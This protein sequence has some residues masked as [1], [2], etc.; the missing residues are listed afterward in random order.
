[1]INKYVCTKEGLVVKKHGCMNLKKSAVI[2]NKR[3]Q[4]ESTISSLNLEQ[5]FFRVFD[6]VHSISIQFAQ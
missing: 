6:K 3:G 2:V 4:T 5:V 1:M